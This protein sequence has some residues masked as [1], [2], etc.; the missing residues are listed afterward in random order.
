MIN[1]IE[2]WLSRW[3]ADVIAFFGIAGLI[4]LVFFLGVAYM[5]IKDRWNG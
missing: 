4:L 5:A 1:Y 3:V 2:F